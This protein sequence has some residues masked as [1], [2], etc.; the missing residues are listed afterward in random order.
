MDKNIRKFK[1]NTVVSKEADQMNSIYMT[2]LP[3]INFNS[4]THPINI[5]NVDSVPRI[6]W[7]KYRKEGDS[8][9]I[10]FSIQVHHTLMDGY[11]VSKY[12]NN[13][14]NKVKN[15]QKYL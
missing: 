2:S 13:F 8:I 6:V 7:G 5:K 10:P 14:K 12:V 9:T 11:H 1:E 3:W 15:L 4:I